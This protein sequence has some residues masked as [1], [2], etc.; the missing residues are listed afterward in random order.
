VGID[1]LQLLKHSFRRTGEG[2]DGDW[3]NARRMLR[4]P[5]GG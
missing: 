2:P 1:F 3:T 4:H 5:W